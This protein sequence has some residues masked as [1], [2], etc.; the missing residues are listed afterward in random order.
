MNSIYSKYFQKSRSFL[1]PILGIKKGSYATPVGTYIA[2]EGF[3]TADEC[4]LI[5]S[6]KKDDSSEFKQFEEQM[7][8]TNPLFYKEMD[9]EKHKLYIF[10][11]KLYEPDWFNFILGKYSKL[12]SV[13]KKAI[14]VYYGEKSPE[15]KYMESYLYPEKFFEDYAKILDVEI[16][17]LKSIGELCNPCD[18]DKET[19]IIENLEIVKK[20][21]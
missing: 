14:K 17:E 20:E 16:K 21:Y 1:Y 9:I 2:L 8:I 12:S 11:L 6:F 5:C 4:K 7:L 15:Y 10:D 13:F 3:Y 18:L 19:L